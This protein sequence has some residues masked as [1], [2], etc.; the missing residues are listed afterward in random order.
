[1][2]PDLGRRASDVSYHPFF[3]GISEKN[4]VRGPVLSE[5]KGAP[6]RGF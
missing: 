6:A 5:V 3:D 2:K 4:R 1:M